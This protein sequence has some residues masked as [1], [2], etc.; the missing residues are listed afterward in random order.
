M[1]NISE[2]KLYKS[3]FFILTYI[4]VAVM[5]LAQL[6]LVVWMEFI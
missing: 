3:K 1:R 5:I 2:R 4:L 6:F